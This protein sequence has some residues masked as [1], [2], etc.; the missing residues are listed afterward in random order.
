LGP[1]PT[2]ESVNAIALAATIGGSLVGLAGVISNVVIAKLRQGQELNLAD[3]QHV[4]E[5]EFARAT[6]FYD[7]RAPIYEAMIAIVAATMEHVH[8]HNPKI[9]FGDE[10][11]LRPEPSL[12]EQHA[13]QT[14]QLTHGSQEVS[15]AF[16]EWR[17]EVRI[18]WVNA[19]K[20]EIAREEGGQL[21]DEREHMDNARE[22]AREAAVNLS[23]LVSDELASL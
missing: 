15:D 16:Y 6:A 12:D 1:T 22:Q 18:F 5:R 11:P 2:I 23:R 3:R 14:K 17:S 9:S 4:H 19:A 21:S 20:F 13:M 8:R 7:R 10:P